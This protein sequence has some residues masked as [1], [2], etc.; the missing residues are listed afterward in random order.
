MPIT[1]PSCAVRLE[2]K[3]K[4]QECRLN[5]FQ[6]KV[7]VKLIHVECQKN[8]RR[9]QPATIS[10]LTFSGPSSTPNSNIAF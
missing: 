1:N 3:L 7:Q 10:P 6:I 8:A 9:K 4:A 5:V 2:Y